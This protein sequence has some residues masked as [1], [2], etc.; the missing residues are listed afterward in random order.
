V[1]RKSFGPTWLWL[2]AIVVFSAALRVLLVRR[3]PAPWIMVDELIYSELGKSFA[4]DGRF[5]VRGVP[6]S[7]YGFVY[8]ILIAPA[9]RLYG[10]VPQAYAA[11]KAI[12][13]VVMS[14]AAVPTYFLARR[15]LS[16]ALSLAAAAL[17][18]L[19]PSMLYTGTLMTENAFYPLFVLAALLLVLTLERPT[20]LRQVVLLAVCG[21]AFATRAQAVA[22]F[23]AA[24][25][26]PILH[27]LIERDVRS[28]PR[29]FAT[30]YGLTA[31]G[32]VVALVGTTARGRS[33]LSLLGAYRAATDRGYSFS[34]IGRYILWHLAELDLALGVVGLAALIAVWLSP[35]STSAGA[36]AFAAATLPIIVLL[37]VEVG[38]FASMQSFRIEERNDFY[39]APFALI[40]MLGL[41]SRDD[42]VP[43]LRRVLFAAALIA[44][45]LPV[46][47]PFAKF[48][49]SSAV[50]DTF[51]LLPWWW[52]QDRGIHF[53]PLRF[54][55]L[56]VGLG[57]AALVFVPRRF[58]LIPAVLVAVYFVLASAIVENGRHGIRQASVGG[59]WAGI[60]VT[61]PDWIDRRVGRAADVSFVWHYA[62]ET[63]P[64]WNN[65]FFNRSVRTVYT[66]D[67]P[68]PAD[69]GLPEIPVHELADGRLATAT[70][71][72]PRV[73]YAVSYTDIAGTRL[74]R[75]P[76]I[77]LALYRV[78][79]PMVILTRVNGLY[80]NDTWSG[81][82]V[83]YRR[84]RCSGGQLSVRLGTDAHLFSGNQV[85]TAIENGHE[86]ASIQIAPTALPTLGV[87]LDPDANGECTVAFTVTTLRVP[88]VV[89]PGSR[90]NRRL[91]AHFFSF[92]YSA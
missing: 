57:A 73:H 79:G 15:L 56:G 10:S 17:A 83:T 26:A 91:G 42:V 80:A 90:D 8:P 31:V 11:A 65:E 54:V 18:V 82:R 50:S 9:F 20:A 39:V 38:A 41:A 53:G 62:G 40:A 25:V 14:L 78:D 81:P 16:P 59:L 46:A 34:E 63:R 28:V 64:L 89:Q 75:D 66:V 30:L 12:N 71:A 92:D 88:A 19:I 60:R 48:V 85:V 13:A 51:G 29:R 77:G 55:A 33:P 87:P 74:A 7:G 76:G 23:G 22:L 32:A 6:S 35:R 86:V 68:D 36:R 21:L 70:G 2:A 1:R 67:G 3:M 47:L 5:L 4:A 45:V 52:L 37:V 43:R 49:N 61:H 24:L 27:G 69:G 72:T 58:A 84:L 44:G